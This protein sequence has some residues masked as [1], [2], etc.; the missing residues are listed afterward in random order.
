[1]L[2]TLPSGGRKLMLCM[3]CVAHLLLMCISSLQARAVLSACGYSD[4]D[5]ARFKDRIF[6][7]YSDD[8]LHAPQVNRLQWEGQCRACFCRSLQAA[9]H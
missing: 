7:A 3:S 8:R 6:L 5:A 1:M 4:W 9:S 2:L